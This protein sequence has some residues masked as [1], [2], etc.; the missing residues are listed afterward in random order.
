M[1][2]A[3]VLKVE[4]IRTDFTSDDKDDTLR[5]LARIFVE[6]DGVLDEE[7]VYRV[8]SDRE[9]LASTGVGS[10]VAIPHGRLDIDDF[11]VAMAICPEGVQFDSVDGEP[12]RIFFAILGPQQSPAEQLKI[13]A[14]VS[15][16]LKDKQVR[17][18]LLEAETSQDA[19]AIVAEE[20]GRH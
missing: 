16:V 7:A 17:A 18:R 19:L 5:E 2:L 13:L 12:A 11:R 20:E 3:D 15:R 4:A 10:G 6:A 1:R 9:E 14:R 8:F